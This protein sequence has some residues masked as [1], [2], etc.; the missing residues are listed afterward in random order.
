[1]KTIEE[2]TEQSNISEDLIK[3]VVDQFGGWEEFTT[4]AEDVTSH[5][6][7]GGFSGFI[8]YNDT[9]AFTENNLDSILEMAKE[10]AESIGC[11][12][13]F[14]MISGFNCVNE[15]PEEV[16]EAIYNSDSE[17]KTSI[18]NALAWYAGEEV[19]RSYTDLLEDI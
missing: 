2:F 1:M 17:N 5:G 16:A 13:I 9:I 19:C 8:Y 11:D 4:Y 3:A 10:Q 6:I 18:L 12:N 7:D 15:T 14:T